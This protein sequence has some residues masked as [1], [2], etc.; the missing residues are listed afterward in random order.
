MEDTG[1]GIEAGVLARLFE[2][3]RQADVSGKRTSGLGI[4]LALVKGLV[5]GHGGRVW[6]ESEGL[7]KGSRF[8]VELPLVADAGGP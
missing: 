3:F 1:I 2:M 4:G 6:A 7:G 8:L 5:E